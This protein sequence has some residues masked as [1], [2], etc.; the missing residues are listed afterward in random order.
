MCWQVR[1]AAGMSR[2]R[3]YFWQE[4]LR[5][6]YKS[7]IS[8]RMASA[9]S[10]SLHN[11]RAESLRQQPSSQCAPRAQHATGLAP[12]ASVVTTGT[13]S[14]AQRSDQLGEEFATVEGA[15]LQLDTVKSA[16]PSSIQIC[17][18]G[19]LDALGSSQL[20]ARRV[21]VR[22]SVCHEFVRGKL[23]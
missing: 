5:C 18:S 11:L 20:A 10:P 7:A 15:R 16:D 12:A 8:V 1:T 2:T 21:Y 9:A 23:W 17:S 6:N 19:A 13:A 22:V 4:G 3:D 14:G